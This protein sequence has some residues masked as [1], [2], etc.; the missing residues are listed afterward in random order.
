MLARLALWA[1]DEIRPVVILAGPKGSGKT[2]LLSAFAAR[3]AADFRI[4][5]LS[6]PRVDP[7]AL[8]LRILDDLGVEGDE[9]R[10]RASL[11][12]AIQGSDGPP[13]LLLVDDA[14]AL[15]PRSEM[16]LFDLVRRSAAALRLVLAVADPRVAAELS[17]AFGAGTEIVAIDTPLSRSE[18]ERLARAECERR[19]GPLLALDEGAVDAIHARS[20]GLPGR[21]LEETIA[22]LARF[23][24]EQRARAAAPAPIAAAEAVAVSLPERAAP[25]SPPPSVARNAPPPQELHAPPPPSGAS[26]EPMARDSLLRWLLVPGALASMFVAGFLASEL[27]QVART[28]SLRE[29]PRMSLAAPP[30]APAADADAALP[31]VAAPPP[32]RPSPPEAAAPEPAPLA[33]AA[34]LAPP[35][36]APEASAPSAALAEPEPAA[37]EVVAPVLPS[38]PAP[39]ARAPAEP[40]ALAATEPT[41]PPAPTATEPARGDERAPAVDPR[42]RG[43]TRTPRAPATQHAA[44]EPRVSVRVSAEPG[45]EVRVDGQSVGAAPIGELQLSRGPHHFVV[46]L[47][48]GRVAERVVDLQGKEYDVRFRQQPSEAE[49]AP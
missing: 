39:E 38:P 13:V 19:G 41:E 43:R 27:L 10:P 21:V 4:A 44:V 1:A 18:V 24:R 46:T 26:R 31:P 49:P 29:R 6:D 16:W 22:A 2:T 5:R 7:D 28:G 8:S 42:L 12:R 36:P 33:P 20:R 23:E 45:A 17:N 3:S 15:S 47:P 11:V 37:P 48:D 30:V 40:P 14:D 35:A 32:A 9:T 25:A 34:P